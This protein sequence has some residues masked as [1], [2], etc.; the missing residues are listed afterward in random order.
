M[1]SHEVERQ[2]DHARQ[3]QERQQLEAEGMLRR[4]VSQAAEKDKQQSLQEAL[5]PNPLLL[6]LSPSAYVLK[7]VSEALV[8]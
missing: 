3:L 1:A 7:S 5:P 2:A 4:G 8:H 6:G